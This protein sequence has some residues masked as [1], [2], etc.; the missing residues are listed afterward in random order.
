MVPVPEALAV[1]GARL[2]DYSGN[3]RASA[4]IGGSPGGPDPEPVRNLLLNEFMVAAAQGN[5]AGLGELSDDWIELW[6]AGSGPLELTGLYLS[7]DPARLDKWPLANAVLPA[8]SYL[9]VDQA[10][11]LLGSLAMPFGLNAQGGELY[12][13]H[14]SESGGSRV[15]DAVRYKGQEPGYSY[16]RVRDL[17]GCWGRSLPTRGGPNLSAPDGLYISEVMYHPHDIV[18]RGSPLDN[19]GDEYIEI[20]NSNPFSV[21]LADGARSWRLSGGVDFLF[22]AGANIPGGGY[23]L[24]VSFDPGIESDFSLFKRKYGIADS[25]VVVVGPYTGK[26]ANSS[27][28]VVLEKPVILETN[29]EVVAWA[30][31]DEVNY[32]DCWPWPEGLADG[33]GSSLQRVAV[34]GCGA[35]GWV[36]LMPTPGMAWTA[37]SRADNDLDGLPDYWEIDNELSPT[38]AEGENG[39]HGDPDGDGLDNRTE[40]M[41]GTRPRTV[42]LRFNGIESKENSMVIRHNVPAGFA[43]R[44]EASES[45]TGDWVEVVSWGAEPAPRFVEAIIPLSETRTGWRFYRLVGGQ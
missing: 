30:V 19:T 32:A 44:V 29:G 13:S 9:L 40:W 16:G 23:M 14:L 5:G 31:V 17:Q 43:V 42:T 41:L 28:A 6:N 21:S 26:L 3:W 27:D 24:V 38:D 20:Y 35:A 7:D 12:L 45:L 37:E 39:G 33:G 8:G 36:A 10:N 18:R 25:G 1:G 2:L 34:P 15:A 11:G 22:P 4:Y